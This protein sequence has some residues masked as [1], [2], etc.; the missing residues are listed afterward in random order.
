MLSSRESLVTN[1]F[2]TIDRHRARLCLVD[3]QE[4]HHSY[5]AVLDLGSALAAGI[6]ER[7]Q[8]VVFEIGNA[9]APLALYVALVR[10]GHVV[11][12]T[13][14]AGEATDRIAAQFA[15]NWIHR[16][17]GTDW[18]LERHCD[19]VH[20]LHPD[21]AILL[22]TSGS[23]GS[24]KFIRLSHG[25]LRSNA[26][27]IA[28]Y[29][30]LHEGERAITALPPFYSYGLSVIHSHL[31][32]GHAIVLS[33][34]SVSE[35][36]FWQAVDRHAVTSLA[37]V[38]H[39]FDLLAR[40]GFLERTHP[41]LRY[42]TQ[43]GGRLPASAVEAFAA[44]A[45][46]HGQRFYVMYGQT[47]AGPRMAYVPPED[48]ARYPG[49]IGRAVPGG[50]L[51]IDPVGGGAASGGETGELVYSGPNVM[52]GY[53]GAADDL[54]RGAEHTELRTGDLATKNDAGY[55][56]IVGRMSRFAK[57]FGLRIGFDELETRLAT[58]GYR[59]SVTGDDAGL[60]VT[61]TEA[62]SAERIGDFVVAALKIPRDLVSVFAVETL[63]LL[64]NGKPDYRALLAQRR[65]PDI[66][67]EKPLR[68]ELGDLLR[69]PAIADTDSF[70]ALGGDSLSFVRAS[71][72][73]EERL[74]TVPDGWERMPIAELERLGAQGGT[75]TGGGG[76]QRVE[77]GILVRAVAI[78]LVVL[79]H[80]SEWNLNGAAFGL[81]I[82]AGMNFGRFLVPKLTQGRLIEVLTA[83][84]F[85]IVVPY[86]VV[87][88]LIFAYVG[89]I[90]AP[91]LLLISNFTEGFYVNGVRR[92]TIYWFIETYIDILF[93]LAL[94]ISIRPLAA[95]IARRGLAAAWIVFAIG[96]ALRGGGALWPG[97]PLFPP[98]GP[99]M[100]VYLFGLG[101]LLYEA[102]G[103]V[104]KGLA[105]AAGLVALYCLPVNG[106]NQ[107]FPITAAMI[108]VLAIGGRVPVGRWG[109][110]ALTV[111]SSAS[112][113]IYIMQPIVLKP[114][115]QLLVGGYMPLPLIPPL[116]L[117]VL[118]L[119][120]GA[121]A[122]ADYLERQVPVDRLSR[123]LTRRRLARVSP[124]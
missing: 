59:A 8:V 87:I 32:T 110:R 124:P 99:L 93:V 24:P 1:L 112:L 28:E 52:M 43:A 3:E 23:T 96:V 63:P 35:P 13:N 9:L 57:L 121:W 82:A 115:K 38:P 14:E 71:M 2:G 51:R 42:L 81:M 118:A 20:A 94:V 12:L 46:T 53:A 54:A 7:R 44:H 16:R 90:H 86:L 73:L 33:N 79:H 34:R 18:A 113:Y 97:S 103:P 69:A 5:G 95:M 89:D 58:A 22:S 119:G 116:V 75:R 36:A 55:F 105:A 29:L 39:S 123:F 30:E 78:L 65:A 67:P 106:M 85:K 66:R 122:V 68:E 72:I 25:N 92:L 45:E 40:T 114:A 102:R 11:L 107:A 74:G 70:I 15:A 50:T 84:L 19:T 27:A 76:L 62:G 80:I 41:S 6:G 21:L 117:V 26:L 10:A 49:C 37:G 100:I 47:E 4:R 101:W 111:V 91:H 104:Q 31:V 61:T 98:L 60:V 88:S 120:I 109:L 77:T 83:S 56:Q 64:A 108:V 48:V 17:R